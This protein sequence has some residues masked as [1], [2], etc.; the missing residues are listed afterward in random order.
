MT[1]P[2]TNEIA[3]AVRLL[4]MA[5]RM[6]NSAI[7]EEIANEA[8]TALDELTLCPISELRG[9]AIQL[10]HLL[11]RYVMRG[12][13]ERSLE[14]SAANLKGALEMERLRQPER[15]AIE[16]GRAA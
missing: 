16:I 10:A 14:V 4:G 7:P 6:G 13:T 9:R 1:N 5:A 15:E 11:I 12:A 8:K 2:E 3:I